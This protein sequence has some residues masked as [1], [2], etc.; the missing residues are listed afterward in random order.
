MISIP[1][2]CVITSRRGEVVVEGVASHGNSH[3]GK[4]VQG[5]GGKKGGAGACRGIPV[6]FPGPTR[7]AGNEG[8]RAAFPRTVGN[9]PKP[10]QFTPSQGSKAVNQ[11][12]SLPEKEAVVP[13][14]VL[15]FRPSLKSKLMKKSEEGDASYKVWS[16]RVVAMM[17]GLGDE[18]D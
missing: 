1:D 8:L 13:G 17:D 11:T 7:I 14:P 18:E 12:N 15:R 9:L 5:T 10:Q 2:V 4:L 6:Q 3:I 16:E